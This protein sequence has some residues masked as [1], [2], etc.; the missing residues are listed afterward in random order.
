[1]SFFMKINSIDLIVLKWKVLLRFNTRRVINLER[2]FSGYAE[3]K[4]F[5]C[6]EFGATTV[7][8]F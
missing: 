6:S 2:M 4:H 7:Y 8:I 5:F 3:G 1:M